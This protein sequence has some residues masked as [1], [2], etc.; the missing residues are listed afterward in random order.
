MTCNKKEAIL[1]SSTTSPIVVTRK[2]GNKKYMRKENENCNITPF[3]QLNSRFDKQSSFRPETRG[4]KMRVLHKWKTTGI[5]KD[6][7]KDSHP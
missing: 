1:Q 5:G 3:V 4:W 2:E 7:Q 6:T